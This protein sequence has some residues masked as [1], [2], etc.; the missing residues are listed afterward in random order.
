MLPGSGDAYDESSGT[1][2]QE[3]VSEL[4][5]QI[6]ACQG[7]GSI[8]EDKRLLFFDTAVVKYMLNNKSTPIF[9]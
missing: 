5:G 6:L 4:D 3:H 2:Y 1:D 8:R 9:K 7:K